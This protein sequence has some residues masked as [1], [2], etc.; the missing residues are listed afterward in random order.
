MSHV[1]TTGQTAKVMR[2]SQQTVI[3][4]ADGGTLQNFRVPGSKF[5]RIFA[6][7]IEKIMLAQS[8]WYEG[9]GSVL[10]PHLLLVT[11]NDALEA[12][13]KEL[14]QGKSFKIVR[15]CTAIEAGHKLIETRPHVALIDENTLPSVSEQAVEKMKLHDVE[16][17]STKDGS[18]SCHSVSAREPCSRVRHLKDFLE[19]AE[20]A[21]F[22]IWRER[23]S[24]MN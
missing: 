15:A 18:F 16:V 23:L 2:V 12:Q 19:V 14:L 9:A 13:T 11:T 7:S 8:M 24:R 6:S 3:R 4:L 22:S 10:Y 5:R 21:A 20:E 1:L 17:F